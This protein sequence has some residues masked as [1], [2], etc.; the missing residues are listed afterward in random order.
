MSAGLGGRNK[1]KVHFR[2]GHGTVVDTNGGN[3]SRGTKQVGIAVLGRV[4]HVG[5][6]ARTLLKTTHCFVVLGGS[7]SC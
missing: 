5:L 7:K 3:P 6:K 1:D 2:K 4:N